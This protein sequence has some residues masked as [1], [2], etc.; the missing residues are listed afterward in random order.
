[1]TAEAM[2]K[3]VFVWGSKNRDFPFFGMNVIQNKFKYGF[4]R[5]SRE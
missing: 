5:R 1:V 4:W 3:A 2:A